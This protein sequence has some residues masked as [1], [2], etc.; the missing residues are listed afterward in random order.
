MACDENGLP[1]ISAGTVIG[2]L[3]GLVSTSWMGISRNDVV[4]RGGP[5]SFHYPSWADGGLV[6]LEA[7]DRNQL[8]PRPVTL[9]T[10][11]P[12]MS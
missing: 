2:M 8:V 7:R 1:V 9:P 4:L 5:G 6:T 10:L 3:V 12:Q 11:L